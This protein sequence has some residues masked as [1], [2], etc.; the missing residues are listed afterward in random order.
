MNHEVDKKDDGKIRVKEVRTKRD[1]TMGPRQAVRFLSHVKDKKSTL[2]DQLKELDELDAK[3]SP[4]ISET[5]VEQGQLCRAQM[6]RAPTKDA[7]AEASLKRWKEV[8][9][10]AGGDEQE[11]DEKMD[12]AADQPDK[13]KFV[14]N[15]VQPPEAVE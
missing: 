15:R 6:E 11:W 8:F 9:L 4:Y 1:Q 7:G 10:L 12:E 5:A 13:E 2:E 14:R 3:L